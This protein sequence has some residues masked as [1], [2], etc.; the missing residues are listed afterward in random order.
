MKALILAAGYATRLYPLTKDR[1][2][3]LIPVAGKPMID[4]MIE[5]L[6][7][8]RSVDKI[9]LCTSTNPQDDVLVD[10]AKRNNIDFFEATKST[11]WIGFIRRQ[12]KR[13]TLSSRTTADNPLTDPRHIEKI[14]NDSLI[15]F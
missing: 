11:C 4:H 5:R 12:K 13:L 14:I 8:A 3:S 6:K 7:T 1:P 2:K 15:L 9:I 10:R